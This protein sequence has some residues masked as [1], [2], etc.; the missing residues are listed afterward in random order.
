MFP[1]SNILY[2]IY[3][4]RKKRIYFLIAS[5][6][7]VLRIKLFT[8]CEAYAYVQVEIKGLSLY[9]VCNVELSLN[10]N[11]RQVLRIF[12][13]MMLRLTERRLRH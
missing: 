1:G 10:G 3:I 8:E 11:L 2:Y 5:K 12:L 9:I 6:H 4:K 7:E 13:L